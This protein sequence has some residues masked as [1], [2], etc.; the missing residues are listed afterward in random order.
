M[1]EDKENLF[2]KK[3]KEYRM[4]ED[5]ENLIVKKS[6][7]EI[8]FKGSGNSHFSYVLGEGWHVTT[9]V[10]GLKQ[11][12]RVPIQDPIEPPPLKRI[13]PPP[14]SPGGPS[15]SLGFLPCP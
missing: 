11:E 14:G 2:V 7:K 1:A 8:I 9:E 12:V 6:D 15:T 10:P 13:H 4:T 5:K 3:C